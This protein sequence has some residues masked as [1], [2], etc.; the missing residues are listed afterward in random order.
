MV[1]ASFAGGHYTGSVKLKQTD[2]GMVPIKL[3]GGSVKVKDEVE[4]SFDVVIQEK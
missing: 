3:F 4:I 1:P 2:F